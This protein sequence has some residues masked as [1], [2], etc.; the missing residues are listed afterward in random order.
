MLNPKIA[1]FTAAALL[2]TTTMI[3]A[4]AAMPLN[5]SPRARKQVAANIQAVRFGPHGCPNQPV[6]GG[7]VQVGT[8]VTQRKSLADGEPGDSRRSNSMRVNLEINAGLGAPRMMPLCRD[9]TC[10][11]N[12]CMFVPEPPA[13]RAELP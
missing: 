7:K 3:G 6:T 1:A 2:G 12:M 9:S 4:A 8:A 13:E 5:G 10:R 11:Q